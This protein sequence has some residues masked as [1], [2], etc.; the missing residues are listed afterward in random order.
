MPVPRRWRRAALRD[1]CRTFFCDRAATVWQQEL[2]ESCL[3]ELKALHDRFG[4][5]YRYLEW[6]DALAILAA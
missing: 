4:V 5:P 1:P 2:H 6:R 3:A